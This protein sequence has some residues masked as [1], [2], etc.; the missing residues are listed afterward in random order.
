MSTVVDPIPGRC[1]CGAVRFEVTP[2]TLFCAHCHCSMCRRLHGAAYVTWFGVPY[3]GFR[4]LAGVADLV[5]YRSSDHGTRSFCRHCGSTLFCESTNHPDWI[6]V[7]LASMERPIDRSP[8][9]HFF[10]DDRADWSHFDDGLP[11]FGGP[12]GVEPR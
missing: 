8:E 10:V 1:F 5:R 6:D 3:T 11:R 2:P 9:T 7:V 4:V 12:T